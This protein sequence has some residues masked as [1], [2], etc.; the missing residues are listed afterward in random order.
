MNSFEVVQKICL[1][2]GVRSVVVLTVNE[3][4]IQKCVS[5]RTFL[6]GLQ[7]KKRKRYPLWNF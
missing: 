3:T 5:I 1:S 7:L 4:T 2:L 6:I